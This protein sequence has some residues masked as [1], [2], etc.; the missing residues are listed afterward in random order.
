MWIAEGTFR[1]GSG[2]T[3]ILAQAS[4]D[5]ARNSQNFPL[6]R[7]GA[8]QNRKSYPSDTNQRHRDDGGPPANAENRTPDFPHPTIYELV[9]CVVGW[10]PPCRS[11]RWI[12][13]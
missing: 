10:R 7:R 4:R 6:W 1:S 8:C 11:S 9:S 3:F 2:Q 12:P 13:F 5:D